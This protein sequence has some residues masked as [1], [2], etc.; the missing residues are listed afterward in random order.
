MIHAINSVLP[1]QPLAVDRPGAVGRPGAFQDILSKA[2]TDVENFR[3]NAET[4][5]GQFLAG[6]GEELHQV[7]MAT[8]QAEL[9][10]E[11]FQGVRNKVVQSYQEIMR[12]QL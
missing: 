9:S 8:Q 1:I 5:V 10:F 3:Q 4:K 7:V 12:M 11:L 2:I 6:E